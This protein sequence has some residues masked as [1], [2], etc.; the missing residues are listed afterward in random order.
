MNEVTYEN[1]LVKEPVDNMEVEKVVFSNQAGEKKYSLK[2]QLEQ[3]SGAID[4]SRLEDVN[5]VIGIIVSAIL[6][7][8]F[9]S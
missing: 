4:T 7:A 5:L 2:D 6:L 3:L 1:G 9:I 8:Y